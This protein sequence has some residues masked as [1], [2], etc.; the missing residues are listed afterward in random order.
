MN[1]A[2][3]EWQEWVERA[4]KKGNLKSNL[5]TS[6]MVLQAEKTKQDQQN[7]LLRMSKKRVFQEGLAVFP[8]FGA[9][10]SSEQDSSRPGVQADDGNTSKGQIKKQR[11]EAKRNEKRNIRER[12]TAIDEKFTEQG[13]LM[14]GAVKELVQIMKEDSV[15]VRNN[16]AVARSDSVTE[17]LSDSVTEVLSE[18]KERVEKLEAGQQNLAIEVQEMKEVAQS[19]AA[20]VAMILQLL[21]RGG[22]GVRID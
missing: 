22:A 1:Q 6:E 21:Q 13:D 12:K 19:T 20:N 5:N 11:L 17:A 18:Q 14:L 3:R 2:L 9:S 7:M 15:V 4:A 10:G 8:Q 16:V